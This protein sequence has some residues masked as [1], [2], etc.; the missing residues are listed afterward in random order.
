MSR[1]I[2]VH[3]VY[4]LCVNDIIICQVTDD[5]LIMTTPTTSL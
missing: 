2:M 4:N 5:K 3:C 1:F